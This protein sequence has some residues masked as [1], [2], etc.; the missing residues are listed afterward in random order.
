[1]Y[2][3]VP[4]VGNARVLT[5]LPSPKLCVPE[6]DIDIGVAPAGFIANTRSPSRPPH[7]VDRGKARHLGDRRHALLLLV[8]VR[9][10]VV[11][12]LLASCLVLRLRDRLHE[13]P[14]VDDRSE[15]AGVE[16]RLQRWIAVGRGER[17]MEAE[18]LPRKVGRRDLE[19]VGLRH[20]DARSGIPY[21]EIARVVR[22]RDHHVIRVVAPEQEDAN[23][24]LVV[25]RLRGRAGQAQLVHARCE[26]QRRKRAGLAKEG[27]AR[28]DE[29]SAHVSAP[30]GTSV[31][32]P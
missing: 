8:A 1:M 25:R 18:H 14:R 16:Q 29:G 10:Q 9:E 26:R 7:P 3:N 24:R 4:P 15:L 11:R 31:I 17:G 6:N 23:E 30:P 19:Q 22:I 27:A 32:P 12:A 5:Y 2:P 21:R 13:R 20:V 28:E